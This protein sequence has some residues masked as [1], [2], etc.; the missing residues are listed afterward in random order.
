MAAAPR[1]AVLQ[2][3]AAGCCKNRPRW[4]N[5][6]VSP[7]PSPSP[8]SPI[9]C[10]VPLCTV[11]RYHVHR[12]GSVQSLVFGLRETGMSGLGEDSRI[13]PTGRNKDISSRLTQGHR[14]RRSQTQTQ[15]HKHGHTEKTPGETGTQTPGPVTAPIPPTA[16][17]PQPLSPPTA[18]VGT[19]FR[20]R[21]Q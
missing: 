15:S 20:H 18:G 19:C 5:R 4:L 8:P 17:G 7:S 21:E 16:V 14:D 10:T 3:A 6:S 11:F 2:A 9:L 1:P 12:F 13:L